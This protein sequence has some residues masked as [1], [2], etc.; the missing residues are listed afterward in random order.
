MLD[1][2]LTIQFR[3]DLDESEK[4]NELTA[5]VQRAQDAGVDTTDEEVQDTIAERE[6][7]G[8]G[9]TTYSWVHLNKFRLFELHDRCYRDQR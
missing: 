5:L 3:D 2:A 8:T 4:R 1:A 7:D 9:T 6:D